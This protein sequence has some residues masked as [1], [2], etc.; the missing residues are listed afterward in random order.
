MSNEKLT[1]QK[2]G[3]VAVLNFPGYSTDR[4][5]MIE[6]SQ[7]LSALCGEIISENTIRVVI[8]AGTSENSFS[9]QTDSLKTVSAT[10]EGEGIEKCSM[11]VTLAKLDRPVIAVIKG[12]ALGP[13]LESV[14]ACDMRIASENARFGLPHIKTGLIPWDGGTQ[15]L[16]RLVG[17]GK[18]MEMILTGEVV[19]ALEAHRIGLVNK[20]V[21]KDKAMT[22]AMDMAEEMAS[23]GPIAL[24]Y[25]K[26]AIYKGMDM[27]LEQGLR[28]EGDLYFLLHTTN[29]RTEGVTAFRD[30][31]TP[32]FQGK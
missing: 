12:D 26:E 17:K 29:D 25:A 1:L 14:L 23:R 24:R 9:I 19:D 21:H 10:G 31:Q 28:L 22:A 15:R 5:T 11:A 3:H 16:A 30:K 27:T 6:L 8:F 2:E 7:E 20:V 18:A 4:E 13:G 32:Q